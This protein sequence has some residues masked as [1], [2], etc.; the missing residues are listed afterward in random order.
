MQA[1]AKLLIV[2]TL[3]LLFLNQHI[4]KWSKNAPPPKKNY[5]FKLINEWGRGVTIKLQRSRKVQSPPFPCW[6]NLTISNITH[7][8]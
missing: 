3:K 6:K 8:S 2:T 7:L 1:N 5:N 4:T